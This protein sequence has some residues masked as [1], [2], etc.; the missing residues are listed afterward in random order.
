MQPLARFRKL[1]NKQFVVGEVY[2]MVAQEE[3]SA[4]S[5][6][7]YFASLHDAWMNL[8]EATAEQFPSSEHLRKYALIQA[9]FRDERSIVC[10]SKAEARRLAAH[11]GA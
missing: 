11:N 3:R 6:R 4:A 2:C 10:A 5:H 1:C 7:Q 9:G 8:P